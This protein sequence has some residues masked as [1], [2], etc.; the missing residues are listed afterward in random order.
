VEVGPF[1]FGILERI[2]LTKGGI[3]YIKVG[4]AFI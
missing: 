3:K 2:F 4:E 1:L